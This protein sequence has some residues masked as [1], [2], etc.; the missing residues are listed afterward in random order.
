MDLQCWVSFWACLNSSSNSL[1]QQSGSSPSERDKCWSVLPGALPWDRPPV[2][3]PWNLILQAPAQVTLLPWSFSWQLQ[4]PRVLPAFEVRGACWHYVVNLAFQVCVARRFLSTRNSGGC[5]CLREEW[6]FQW[7]PGEGGHSWWG[8][9]G[10]GGHSW[11]TEWEQASRG[12]RKKTENTA[13]GEGNS[14]ESPGWQ[15][16]GQESRT[17]YKWLL[18]VRAFWGEKEMDT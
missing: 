15:R 2:W 12:Q 5:S 8:L 13:W 4:G 1:L 18:S 6:P 11:R 3:T 17:E 9:S 10:K 14:L 16:I 7:L